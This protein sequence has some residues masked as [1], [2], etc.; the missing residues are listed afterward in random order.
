MKLKFVVPFSLLAVA[1]CSSEYSSEEP[2]ISSRRAFAEFSEKGDVSLSDKGVTVESVI[3][4][5][6]VKV[7]DNLSESEFK[8]DAKHFDDHIEDNKSNKEVAVKTITVEQALKIQN[9]QIEEKQLEDETDELLNQE[10]SD[11]FV[12]A[13]ESLLSDSTD[14]E[15]T[16]DQVKLL[17]QPQ[18]EVR[19]NVEQ[20]LSEQRETIDG[21]NGAVELLKE[22]ADFL[23]TQANE[24]IAKFRLK[25]PKNNN[26]LISLEQLKKIDPKNKNISIIEKSIGEKYLNLA[27]KKIEEGEKSAAQNYLNSANEFIKDETIFVDYQAKI[28]AT[29]KSTPLPPAIAPR[30]PRTPQQ[31]VVYRTPAPIP[32]AAPIACDPVVSFSGIPLIG[33]QSFT[34]QQSLPISARSALDKS[35]RAVRLTYNRVIASGNQITYQ[36]ATSTNP[37]KFTLT[38]IPSGNYSQIRIK[39]KM[40]TGI[41]LKKSGYRRGFCDLL[42]KF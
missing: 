9:A 12:E 37:I 26:A 11:E 8:L 27:S 21:S 29:K 17:D 38:V 33:G 24:H 35:A 3:D 28:E 5:S 14:S 42:A 6:L 4:Q 39:A 18:E 32:P 31:R 2:E 1:S 22:Q 41:V 15:N 16:V 20:L 36:Q 30:V 7:E 19:S 23:V 13:K 10:V 25:T 34:A 40:P